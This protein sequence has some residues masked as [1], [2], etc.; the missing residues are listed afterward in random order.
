MC[1]TAGQTQRQQTPH[2]RKGKGS[3]RR[4]KGRELKG[5]RA[6]G[7]D[8]LRQGGCKKRREV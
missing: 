8:E 6:D 3:E 4:S 2:S 1:W 7:K 5:R